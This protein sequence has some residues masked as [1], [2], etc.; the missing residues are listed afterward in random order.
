MIYLNTT[1]LAS[2]TLQE[3]EQTLRL[4]HYKAAAMHMSSMVRHLQLIPASTH[5]RAMNFG[6]MCVMKIHCHIA[7]HIK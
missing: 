4:P 2:H 6:I 3:R 1:K 7:E 5:L